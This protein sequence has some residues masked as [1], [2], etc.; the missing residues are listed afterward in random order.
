[1]ISGQN[2]KIS[3]ENVNIEAGTE[4]LR[5]K[6][7][8]EYQKS[9]LTVSLSSPAIDTIQ[10][11]TNDV[12]R[13][14]EVSDS[15]LSALYDVKAVQELKG[16]DQKI[17]NT[18]NGPVVGKDKD[19]N[20][21]R[22]SKD[23]SVNIGLGSTS[24]KQNSTSEAI[25]AKGSQITAGKNI[26]VIATGSN[27]GDGNVVIEGST[28]T[29]DKVH[30]QAAK[31]VT[32]ESAEN[33]TINN[34]Q[35]DGKSSGIGVKVSAQG[36][37]FYV[38]GSKNQ[39]IEN[40]TTVSH[41]QSVITAKDTL[42]IESGKD[43]NILGS[44]VNGDRVEIKAGKD[45]NIAS[46]QDSDNY[47]SKNQN[48]GISISSGPLGNI[49]GSAGKGKIDSNYTSVTEQAGIYAGRNGFDINVGKNTDLKG[50]VI[51]SDAT[52][53]KNKISTDT[54]TH[55]DIQNKADYSASSSGYNLDTVTNIKDGGKD[56]NGKQVLVAEKNLSVSPD[57]STSVNGNASSTTKSGIA[58]GTIEVR[59]GNTD[60]S[61]LNRN[62]NDSLNALGK[63]FD[64]KKVQEQQELTKVFG[65]EAYKAI[66]DL[67]LNQYQKA[68]DDAAKYKE[69]TPEY[70]EAMA[71]ADSWHDGG[72][73]K[74]LLHAV[75]GGIMSD[76]GGSSFTSGATSA[77]LNEAVQNELAKIKDAGIHQLVSAAIGAVV[78]KL[79]GGNA[80]TGAATALSGT[81]YNWLWHYQQQ[82]M[83]R[84]LYAAT[85]MEE[86]KR[87]VAYYAALS[88]YNDD[89]TLQLVNYDWA[90]YW[91]CKNEAIDPYLLG[92][93]GGL[94]SRTD[95]GLNTTLNELTVSILG[96]TDTANI[97]RGL[98]NTYGP[99]YFPF[100]GI[101][102]STLSTSYSTSS[103]QQE[104]QVSLPRTIYPTAVDGNIIKENGQYKVISHDSDGNVVKTPVP[105]SEV[106]GEKRYYSPD[107][108]SWFEHT[109]KGDTAIPPVRVVGNTE[110]TVDPLTGEDTYSGTV[111]TSETKS[112]MPNPVD[113]MA[114]YFAKT[115]L[116]A[117]GINP[118]NPDNAQQLAAEVEKQVQMNKEIQDS[119][120]GSVGGGGFK[121]FKEFKAFLGSP[122][123][124]NQWHHIVEQA[125]Q[126]ANRAGFDPEEINTVENII[127]LQS[128]KDSVHSAISG[129]YSSKPYW[130]GGLTVRD[131]LATKS[132]EEQFDYGM[133]I[134]KNY[135][136]VAKD[137]AGRWTF[138]PF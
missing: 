1:M 50:A 91:S 14:K 108:N 71:R 84:L 126:N 2:T 120:M 115:G 75:A 107:S 102:Q 8:Y 118:D 124:G 19:G 25:Q 92:A 44:K 68:L 37:G 90:T 96:V 30:I 31:D 10:S 9:G 6:Q 59:S 53:D 61:S 80:Q 28:V 78:S 73:N 41:T 11:I 33:R 83:A 137:S 57:I 17:D 52:P 88:Q 69:G 98:I 121:T 51:A 129:F 135:G 113:S 77:G 23:I 62:T 109:E 81:K 99:S 111:E 21:V 36:A 76:L 89:N 40:G 26:D 74:I 42:K 116:K 46:Q 20:I 138:T 56:A 47:N 4:N 136:I 117:Q 34:T 55:S 43:T 38:E 86:K 133:N 82:D 101:P 114:L 127:A 27:K 3:G 103:G 85:S 49:T 39:G 104:T 63:I 95:H 5:E 97:Y 112:G 79:V 128:G 105:A 13:A 66:G 87:I 16:L 12:K 131:W 18:V 7:S 48:S 45:L 65:Q 64:K 119:V 125:Q 110:W 32:I 134:L 123:A 100:D 67:A 22:G 24:M 54:L 72:D 58:Q 122:G 70:K 132:F 94:T 106:E 29:G 60:L 93:L 35:S 15:R 130:T